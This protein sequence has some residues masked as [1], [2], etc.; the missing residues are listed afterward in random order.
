MEKGDFS[1][2]DII[3]FKETFSVVCVEQ[4]NHPAKP[5]SSA[6]PGHARDRESP[7]SQ[8]KTLRF[9]PAT[10][11]DGNRPPAQELDETPLSI[12]RREG[13]SLTGGEMPAR[14]KAQP[15]RRSRVEPRRAR[16]PRHW[17]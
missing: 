11:E 8:H 14:G 16:S 13:K 3:G 1:F 5:S 15:G 2:K 6:V 10:K 17:E 4:R 7:G 12:S 9:L